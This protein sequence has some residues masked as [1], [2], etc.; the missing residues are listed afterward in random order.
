MIQRVQSV[1]LFLASL[2]LFFLLILPILTKQSNTGDFWFQVG[3]FYQRTN[4]I[5]QRIESYTALFGG[6]ILVGLI[7]LGNIFTFRNRTLQKRIVLLTIVLILALVGW[8][9]S[10]AFKI[11][12][13]IDGA[14]FNI[15]AYLPILSVLFCVLAHRGI[16]KDEQLIRSADRLR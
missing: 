2:T 4:H 14:T 10:Y 11:P 5:A 7:C 13:G 12:G 8:I 16:R 9:A 1:W 3:G 6:T 15:G